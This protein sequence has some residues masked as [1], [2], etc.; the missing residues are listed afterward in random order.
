MK[1]RKRFFLFLI[2]VILYLLGSLG[3]LFL[4]E[5]TYVDPTVPVG[6]DRSRPASIEE[7]R[8][9]LNQVDYD[10]LISIPSIGPKLARQILQYRQEHGA[11]RSVEELDL[12]PGIG[13]KKLRLLAD[14]VYVED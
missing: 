6:G 12:V 3:T 11:F 5:P 14:Y 10:E 1:S 13:E 9:D 8:V 7:L 4:R 2:P